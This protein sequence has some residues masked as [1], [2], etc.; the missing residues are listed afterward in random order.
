MDQK[1]KLT[2]LWILTVIGMILHF[3]YHIGE[4]VY[5]ADI[6]KHEYKGEEPLAIL[7]IR[8]V[9]Y[10]LPVVWVLLL[11]YFKTRIL[12]LILFVISILYSISHLAHLSGELM[13][14]SKNYSQLSLLSLVF[15]ISLLI[16]REHYSLWKQFKHE[17]I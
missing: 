15:I 14:S 6:V 9:Y 11:L 1:N 7:F 2:M 3:N 10:H 17:T 8:N 12:Y 4:M 13:Q 16:V 5:G